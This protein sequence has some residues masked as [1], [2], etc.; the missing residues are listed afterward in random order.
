MKMLKVPNKAPCG[1]SPAIT[2]KQS[3]SAPQ[4]EE[5]ESPVGESRVGFSLADID[6]FPRETVQLKLRLG[7]VGDRYEQEADQVASR[8]VQTISSSDMDLVQRTANASLRRKIVVFSPARDAAVSPGVELAIQRA[9]SGGMPLQEGVRQPMERAFG[10]DFGGVRVHVDRQADSLNRSLQARAFTIG[11]DIFLRHGEYRP[12]SSEGQRLLA[13]EL[14]HV[15]QQVQR[16]IKPTGKVGRLPLNDSMTLVAESDFMRREALQHHVQAKKQKESKN[17]STANTVSQRKLQ[18]T[19]NSKM[20]IKQAGRALGYPLDAFTT[21]SKLPLRRRVIQRLKHGFDLVNENDDIFKNLFVEW[22]IK[23]FPS[24][25]YTITD[26]DNY[27]VLKHAEALDFPEE[28][29]RNLTNKK[30]GEKYELIEKFK[31]IVSFKDEPVLDMKRGLLKIRRNKQKKPEQMRTALLG[32]YV[33][34]GDRSTHITGTLGAFVEE[35]LEPKKETRKEKWLRVADED[36]SALVNAEWINSM[37]SYSH[38]FKIVSPMTEEQNVVVR[39]AFNTRKNG[40]AF[41]IALRDMFYKPNVRRSKNPLWDDTRMDHESDAPSNLAYEI[42]RLLDEG[43]YELDNLYEDRKGMLKVRKR[44]YGHKEA[45]KGEMEKK[46][47]GDYLVIQDFLQFCINQ[48]EGFVERR[49]QGDNRVL[50]TVKDVR[51]KHYPLVRDKWIEAAAVTRDPNFKIFLSKRKMI[52]PLLR[53][54]MQELD[55]LL[56]AE[57]NVRNKNKPFF[58]KILADARKVLQGFDTTEWDR[59]SK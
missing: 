40:I 33:G 27:L 25:Q 17:Q 2:K 36:W 53:E 55:T 15:V 57:P 37:I 46:S 8:V 24:N 34:K 11:R 31:E 7:P 41:L 43:T 13:H 5:H 4:L 14:T 10:A 9:R 38:S 23:G 26:F 32:T 3:I 50:Q 28:E 12:A 45:R 42:A 56:I 47:H 39:E 48:V 59:F 21:C 51:K 44:Q 58:S 1:P 35:A 6:I 29:I 16:R 18:E 22:V 52:Q 49:S 54:W 19:A 20:Q 30:Y